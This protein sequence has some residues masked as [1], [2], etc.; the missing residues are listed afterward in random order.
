MG[1]LPLTEMAISVKSTV[2][3]LAIAPARKSMH[4]VEPSGAVSKSSVRAH[5]PRAPRGTPTGKES[6]S[7][8][9]HLG[10]IARG[11]SLQRHTQKVQRGSH[12]S[13]TSDS[14]RLC[15]SCARHR[16]SA[17]KFTQAHHMHT[18]LHTAAHSV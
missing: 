16:R 10:A 13:E 1:S 5:T 8:S 11:L 6:N 14:Q 15:A 3:G 7:S 9:H 18:A 2:C 4:S 12:S 17:T